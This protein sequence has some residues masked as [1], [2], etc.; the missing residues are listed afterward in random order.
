MLEQRLAQ[1]HEEIEQMRSM[2]LKQQVNTFNTIAPPPVV[3][4]SPKRPSIVKPKEEVFASTTTTEKVA[5]EDKWEALM[6]SLRSKAYT[7]NPNAPWLKTFRPHIT[8]SIA[9]QKTVFSDTTDKDLAVNGVSMERIYRGWKIDPELE[10]QFG[11][12]KMRMFEDIYAEAQTRPLNHQMRQYLEEQLDFAAQMYFK[13]VAALKIEEKSVPVSILVNSPTRIGSTGALNTASPQRPARQSVSIKADPQSIEFYDESQP[14]LPKFAS[15]SRS[16][17]DDDV[18]SPLT[19]SDTDVRLNEVLE[20]RSAGRNVSVDS[21][22]TDISES[23]EMIRR[24][25]LSNASSIGRYF[26]VSNFYC[27]LLLN[28]WFLVLLQVQLGRHRH[29]HAQV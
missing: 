24:R 1:T 4:E 26:T 28:H 7:P 3:N 5:V 27:I 11:Q 12:L 20:P 16:T 29:Q 2:L 19:P 18:M 9:A 6:K 10:Y 17:A 15:P 21:T 8:D 14:I 23:E 22:N 13:D 25:L